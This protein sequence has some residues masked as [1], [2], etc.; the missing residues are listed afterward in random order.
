MLDHTNPEQLAAGGAVLSGEGARDSHPDAERVATLAWEML[1][2][3]YA[4]RSRT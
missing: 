3:W 2:R 4:E 1:R